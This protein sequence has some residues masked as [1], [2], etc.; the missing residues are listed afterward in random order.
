VLESLSSDY[1]IKG[2]RKKLVIWAFEAFREMNVMAM[3]EDDFKTNL[4]KRAEDLRRI[5]DTKD[6]LIAA[7]NAILGVLSNL[8]ADYSTESCKIGQLL[9]KI[10]A[11]L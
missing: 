7:K 9:S 8:G 5:T 10:E 6:S 3:L 2:D 11:T 1:V 4:E